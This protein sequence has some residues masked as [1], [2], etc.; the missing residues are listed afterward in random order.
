MI[1]RYLLLTFLTLTLF[2]ATKV[3]AQ[4]KNAEAAQKAYCDCIHQYNYLAHF[5]DY[6]SS[7]YKCFRAWKKDM[8][9]KKKECQAKAL[10]GYRPFAAERKRKRAEWKAWKRDVQ[11]KNHKEHG[12]P[13]DY[14]Y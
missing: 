9:R 10:D 11:E 2:G 7:D 3:M 1:K 14:W 6:N 5:D 8:K 12:D 4:E 13:H